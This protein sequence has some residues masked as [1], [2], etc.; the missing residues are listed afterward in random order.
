MNWK[1]IN[2]DI[3]VVKEGQTIS[4]TFESTKP[5]DIIK[6]Q[7]GC[8]S[9]T[10]VLSYKDNILTVN[11]NTGS[12]PVHLYNHSVKPK[13]EGFVYVY[14]KDGTVDMLTFNGYLMRK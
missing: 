9:C 3:G 4:I 10:K 12:F 7:V 2:K 5:L 1:E 13:I 11:Y 14:L 8:S 6:T